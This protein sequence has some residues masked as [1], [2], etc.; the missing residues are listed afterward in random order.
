MWNK[1]L[2]A[3]KYLN[4]F[5]VLPFYEDFSLRSDHNY[6]FSDCRKPNLVESWR[7]LVQH[8]AKYNNINNNNSNNNNENN[9]NKN[10][11]KSSILSEIKPENAN[12]KECRSINT[13]SRG[14]MKEYFPSLF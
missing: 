1:F 14:K 9:T 6:I 8:T 11:H 10:E 2:E 12:L 5:L 3:L 4:H 13:H 7:H